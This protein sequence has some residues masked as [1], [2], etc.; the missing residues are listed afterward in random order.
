MFPTALPLMLRLTWTIKPNASNSDKAI[1]AKDKREIPL[2]AGGDARNSLVQAIN[3]TGEND[4]EPVVFNGIFPKFLRVWN[5]GKTTV[6]TMLQ[7]DHPPDLYFTYRNISLV[8][9]KA[10]GGSGTYLEEWWDIKEMCDIRPTHILPLDSCGDPLNVLSLFTFN[11]KAFP[12]TLTFLS[13]G[14]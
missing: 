9:K 8:L 11:D 13:G 10:L 3:S 6:P 4:T 5:T 7:V 12:S 14:G 1:V 2:L